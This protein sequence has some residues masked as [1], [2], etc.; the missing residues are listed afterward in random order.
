MQFS[1]KIFLSGMIIPNW[2]NVATSQRSTPQSWVWCLPANHTTWE[3]SSSWMI[4]TL[5]DTI[6]SEIHTV[7]LRKCLM[8]TFLS[9]RGVSY[10][11]TPQ[12]WDP[13]QWP[14]RFKTTLRFYSPWTLCNWFNT[15]SSENFFVHVR[16]FPSERNILPNHAPKNDPRYPWPL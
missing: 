9:S 3:I 8:T 11:L 5:F 7:L 4:W 2:D 13:S 15:N 10:H 12:S 16:Y 1:V 6:S 14:P